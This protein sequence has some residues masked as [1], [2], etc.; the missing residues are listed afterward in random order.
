VVVEGDDQQDQTG[1]KAEGK[2]LSQ[3]FHRK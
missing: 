2:W 3:E 1:V